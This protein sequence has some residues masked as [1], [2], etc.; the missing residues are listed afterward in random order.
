MTRKRFENI[1]RDIFQ[2][3]EV[4]CSAGGEHCADVIATALN[5]VIE[6]R[7]YY[8]LTLNELKNAMIFDI[9]QG[10]KGYSKTQLEYLV[11]VLEK[12]GD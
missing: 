6:E 1:G 12:K 7:D 2:Y 9:E 3:G 5:Q 11:S 4:W 10:I 8:K